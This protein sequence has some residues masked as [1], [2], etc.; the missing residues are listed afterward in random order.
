MQPALLPVVLL[1]PTRA[2]SPDKDM[3]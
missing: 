1:L 2:F 3:A